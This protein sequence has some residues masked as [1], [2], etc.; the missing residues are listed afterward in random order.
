[1]FRDEARRNFFDKYVWDQLESE[2][3]NFHDWIK[4][5]GTPARQCM[6]N[7]IEKTG[8]SSMNDNGNKNVLLCASTK[9]IPVP[10]R[11]FPSEVQGMYDYARKV[12]ESGYL[13][14]AIKEL[15]GKYF[16]GARGESEFVGRVNKLNPD[17]YDTY[18][19]PV[20]AK[21][22]AMKFLVEMISMVQ[23]GR[24][25]TDKR[26]Q[27][28]FYIGADADSNEVPQNDPF[29]DSITELQTALQAQGYIVTPP[30]AATQDPIQNA[31]SM[32]KAIGYAVA[33]KAK[34]KK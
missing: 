4:W 17:E 19:K 14:E 13:D 5:E 20:S 28:L 2:G 3:G 25:P 10:G 22:V 12:V 9:L 23:H 15:E 11:R 18:G 29:K 32:L 30:A 27:Q 16:Y 1:L 31:I 34:G 33:P 7:A 8:G 26:E 24:T 6:E 21:K